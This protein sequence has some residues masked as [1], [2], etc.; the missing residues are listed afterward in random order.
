MKF[1]LI[2]HIALFFLFERLLSELTQCD[3]NYSSW[4]SFPEAETTGLLS[5]CSV[6]T[7]TAVC[8]QA[9]NFWQTGDDRVTLHKCTAV[10]APWSREKEK[11]LRLSKVISNSG[12]NTRL[13]VVEK[14][15]A[16]G[17]FF[18]FISH[19]SL[20]PTSLMSCHAF[21]RISIFPFP[22]SHLRFWLGLYAPSPLNQRACYKAASGGTFCWQMGMWLWLQMK[23]WRSIQVFIS[24]SSSEPL[25]YIA[26]FFS[27]IC[28]APPCPL[29]LI[30]TPN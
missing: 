3:L 19:L 1:D 14:P 15:W 21:I 7:F 25:H 27:S 12:S 22:F 9:W 13:D 17:P 20:L 4:F 24:F 11:L 16:A 23:S 8:L 18:S 6:I 2:N 10:L 26:R 29:H 30:S 28:L 5:V